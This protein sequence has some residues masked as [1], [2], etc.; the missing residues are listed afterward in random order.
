MMICPLGWWLGEMNLL[1]GCVIGSCGE[2]K[3]R[4]QRGNRAISTIETSREDTIER[5]VSRVESR[6]EHICFSRVALVKDVRLERILF[7]SL[8]VSRELLM[9]CQGEVCLVVIVLRRI[10][11]DTLTRRLMVAVVCI[12]ARARRGSRVAREH[13]GGVIGCSLLILGSRNGAMRGRRR[14]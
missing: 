6:R 8:I 1:K 2:R 5:S 13:V 11:A 7:I 12:F 10:V 9:L 3:C 14:G 4:W